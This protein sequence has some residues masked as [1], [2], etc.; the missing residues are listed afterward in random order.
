MRR[1]TRN[2]EFCEYPAKAIDALGREAS[3]TMQSI[4]LSVRELV[5]AAQAIGFL[6]VARCF[7]PCA[8]MVLINRLEN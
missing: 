6:W 1:G 5:A 4:H 8:W 2:I 7:N 3:R